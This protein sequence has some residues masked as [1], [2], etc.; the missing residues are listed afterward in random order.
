MPRLLGFV[1]FF[2]YTAE[3][4]GYPFC[5]IPKNC[6][7]DGPQA[8]ILMALFWGTILYVFILGA[9]RLVRNFGSRSG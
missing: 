5:W 6:F 1:R 3:G 2:E 9:R 7:L 8:L 4:M